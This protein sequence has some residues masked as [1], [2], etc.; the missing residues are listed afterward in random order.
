MFLG[1]YAVAF[2]AKRAAPRTSLGMLMVAAE[3][4]DHVWPVFILLGIE[5]VRIVPGFMAA[6]PLDLYD[7]PWS[8]GLVP[9]LG[10]S[11]VLGGLYYLVRRYG[12]GGW[13]IAAV[14]FSHWVLDLVSHGP[15]L[16]LIPGGGPKLGLGLWNSVPGTL[17]VEVG[18]FVVGVGLYL[19]GTRARD[20][21][22]SWGLYGLVAF[23]LL[24]Y[25]GSSFGPPPPD[26]RALAYSALFMWVFVPWGWWVDRHRDPRAGR[27]AA[28]APEIAPGAPLAASGQVP[29]VP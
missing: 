20:R 28:G 1:H 29:P 18:L 25:V 24:G 3:W 15:D 16:P 2:G 9:V 22:G 26:S 8:H 13:V 21:I 17:V 14:V 7:Y 5:H 23:L 19:R 11:L 27:V 4:L 10:W 12:R 6:N